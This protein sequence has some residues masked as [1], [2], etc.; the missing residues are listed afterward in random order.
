MS[1]VNGVNP[2]MGIGA[3][4]ASKAGSISMTQQMAIEWGKFE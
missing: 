3:Y 1:S 4:P 2:G